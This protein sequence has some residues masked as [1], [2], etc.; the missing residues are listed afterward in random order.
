MQIS[1]NA[2]L[3]NKAVDTEL[4]VT[5]KQFRILNSYCEEK[6]Q[7]AHIEVDSK[8]N[9]ATTGEFNHE[10]EIA[11]DLRKLGLSHEFGLK[12]VTTRKSFI[13]DHTVDI[14]FQNKENKYQYSLY[15]HPNE[16]GAQLT[17]PKRVIAIEGSIQASGYVFSFNVAE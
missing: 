6:Q 17:T 11:V 16:A 13:L 12:G 15:V 1:F 3:G 14:Y 10:L 2:G 9:T 4:K 8:T 5:N 7:C